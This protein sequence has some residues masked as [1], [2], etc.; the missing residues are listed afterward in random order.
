MPIETISIRKKGKYIRVSKKKGTFKEYRRQNPDKKK[1]I[2]VKKRN[3]EKERFLKLIKERKHHFINS[4]IEEV[5]QTILKKDYKTK[6]P[7][8]I[9][10]KRRSQYIVRIIVGNREIVGRSHFAYYK[11]GNK[12]FTNN[13]A[14]NEAWNNALRLYSVDQTGDSDADEGLAILKTTK[15]NIREGWVYYREFGSK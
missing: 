1:I 3:L 11:D 13:Q 5:E 12:R 7:Y 8:N 10:H 9:P 6:V 14:R 2:K 4:N 15:P